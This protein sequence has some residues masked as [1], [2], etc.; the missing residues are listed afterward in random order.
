MP[1]AVTAARTILTRLH[2]VMA[3]RSGPCGASSASKGPKGEERDSGALETVMVRWCKKLANPQ[4][5]EQYA[6]VSL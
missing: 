6:I 3:S 5:A 2:E 4:W 1:T